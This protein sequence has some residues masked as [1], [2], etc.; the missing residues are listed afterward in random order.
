MKHTLEHL[1]ADEHYHFDTNYQ[2]H[3]KNAANIMIMFKDVVTQNSTHTILS[4]PI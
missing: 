3:R 4:D 1:G 2:E